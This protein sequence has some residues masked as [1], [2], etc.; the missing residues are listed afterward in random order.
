MGSS[1]WEEQAKFCASYREVFY[2][3]R[4]YKLHEPVMQN[5]D[6]CSFDGDFAIET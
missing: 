5:M 3:W 1:Y 4:Y 6:F 2:R